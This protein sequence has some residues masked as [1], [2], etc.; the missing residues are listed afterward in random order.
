V[1]LSRCIKLL[2]QGKT[3]EFRPTGNSMT[4]RIVSGQLVRVAP[5]DEDVK[6]GDIVLAKVK[7]QLY[8]HKV[9]AIQGWR[10]QIS[11]NH[12]HINGWTTQER[13]YGVVVTR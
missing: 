3:V 7:G 6:V 1:N 4:P 10:V 13:I 12:G 5:R 2:Q 8:L 9:S 11:N